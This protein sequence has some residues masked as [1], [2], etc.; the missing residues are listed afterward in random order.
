MLVQVQNPEYDRRDIWQFDQPQYHYYEG[1]SVV[2]KHVGAHELALST[3]HADWPFR[4]IQRRR[5][6]A[7]DG[8]AY[9][10]QEAEQTRTVKGSRG[11]VYTV[12][13]GARPACTCTGFQYR[14]SCKHTQALSISHV[15]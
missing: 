7:I 6:V 3:G 11:D 8:A 9:H 2:V 14:K 10:Y 1:D 13:L 15:E 4:V 5:I 12:T